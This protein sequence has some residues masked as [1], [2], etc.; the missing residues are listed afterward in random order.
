MLLDDGR[1]FADFVADIIH[2]RDIRMKSDGAISR[3]FCYLSDA[4]AGFFT[5]LL[6]GE[7]G[8]AYNIA[9]SDAE[10][11]IINLAETLVTLFPERNLKVIRQERKASDTYLQSNILRSCPDISKARGLGWH[12]VIG[13]R[14]GFSLTIRSYL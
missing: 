4:V 14:E 1:V 7:N 9:N 8:H 12:P 6:K 5:V 10:I 2:G 3:A 13:I 11:T